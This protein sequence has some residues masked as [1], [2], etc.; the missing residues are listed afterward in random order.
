MEILSK[1][2]FF[3]LMRKGALGNTLN[4]WT[5]VQSALDSGVTLFGMREIGFAGGG[6]H[7]IVSGAELPIRAYQWHTFGRRF[8]IDEA[9]PDSDVQLQG[10]LCRGFYGLEGVLG[11]RTGCRMRQ[12]MELNLLK[13]VRGAESLYLL[14]KFI[15][16]SSLDDMEQIWDLYPEA[17]IEFASYPYD[18]GK[19]P[20]RNTLI[21]EVRNY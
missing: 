6:A 19:I 14:R 4:S 3:E 8:L 11:V 10:E 21:W 7:A 17:V 5:S 1:S 20:G 9:A 12:A 13:P 2:H 18:L 16:P 15:D